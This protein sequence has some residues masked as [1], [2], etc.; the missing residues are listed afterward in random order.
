MPEITIADL[1]KASL[2]RYPQRI[3][4][5]EVRGAEARDLLQA[6]NTGHQGSFSTIHANDAI[7]ALARLDD[8][9]VSSSRQAI[10]SAVNLVA[11]I[12]RFEGHGHRYVAQV[13]RVDGYERRHDRFLTTA[14]YQAQPI[15]D[16]ESLSA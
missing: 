11:H 13:I 2:R 5:G 4:L 15:H 3:I 10:A 9:A 7:E 12:E 1:L 16:R 14:L 6:L 8:L